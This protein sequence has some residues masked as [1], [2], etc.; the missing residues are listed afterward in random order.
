MWS[1]TSDGSIKYLKEDGE[2]FTGRESNL[3]LTGYT[4]QNLKGKFD[5]EHTLVLIP[6]SYL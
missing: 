2:I 6:I 5:C 1:K 3:C 4:G